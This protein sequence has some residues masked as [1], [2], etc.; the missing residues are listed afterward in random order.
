MSVQSRQALRMMKFVAEMKKNNYPN[1]ASFAELLCQADVDENF[2]CACSPRTVQ[3]DIE[4]LQNDYHAPMIY[5]AQQRGYYLKSPDWE[6]SVPILSDD[7]LSMTLLGTK[8]AS[9]ILPEPLRS[10]VNTAVEKT[11]TGNRSEFFDEAMIESL[12]CASGIKAKVD[13]VIFKKVFDGWRL[14]QVVAI[15]YRKPNGEESERKIEPHIIAF[16]HGIWYAKGYEYRTKNIK[17]YAIQ[18]ILSARFGI[19][20][21][22][23]DKKLLAETKRNGLFEYPRIE[24][25]R[26]LCDPSIAFYL[27]EHQKIKKFKLER[28]KDGFLVITLRPAFEHDV[29]RWILGEG[30]KISVLDP[31]GLREKIAAAGKRIAE[32]NS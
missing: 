27:Y 9:D 16:H 12:L 15:T 3:R 18:R 1:A 20:T 5:D 22:E 7:I 4:T 6:F 21:F 14:H 25:V 19:D 8:L 29:I 13:P 2:S 31:P 30:G 11:L 28:R 17:S 24:G 10:D 32:K 26:L 23:T